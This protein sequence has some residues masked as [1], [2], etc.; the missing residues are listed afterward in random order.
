MKIGILGGGQLARMLALAAIPMGL[1]IVCYSDASENCAEA[2][3]KVY[4]G[5]LNDEKAL[6]DFA[7]IVD[8]ITFENENIPMQTIEF[9]SSR[10]TVVPN[11]YAMQT[12]Q[13]RLLE[14]RLFT[15]LHIPTTE[16]YPADTLLEAHAAFE[17]LKQQAVMKTRRLGYDGKG[18]AVVYKPEDLTNN[19]HR[20][21]EVPVIL[22]EIVPFDFEVSQLAVRSHEGKIQFYPLVE[23][24]HEQGI[25]RLSLAPY[26]DPNLQDLA[27]HY[28]QAL[29][30]HFNYVG[31]I[32]VE[33]FVVGSKL[34]A[35]EF[36]PR[37][38]NSGHWTI[39]G[40]Y[41]SQF[42]NHLRAV[43]GLPLGNCMARGNSAMFNCIGD[44]ATHHSLRESPFLSWHDYDKS[45]RK[46]RKVGHVTLNHH[47]VSCFQ[48]YCAELKRHFALNV[49]D[50]ANLN[51]V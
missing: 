15:Q 4:K 45:P 18:Q 5:A 49:N 32:A 22:E 44:M 1:D 19:W 29:L 24:Y 26:R 23:N 8:V 42:N 7:A 47:D 35:N 14:K 13:D 9:L 11:G 2:V 6:S 48:S 28:T 30:E 10:C 41:T 21:N 16:F 20:V 36:A 33:Y 43:A 25:L 38:H 39:E 40:A 17:T 12:A 31:V 37:V 34:L 27:Q 46:S 50:T 51:K 3:C